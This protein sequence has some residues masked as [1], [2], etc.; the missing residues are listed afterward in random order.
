MHVRDPSVGRKWNTMQETWTVL[1]KKADFYGIASRFGIDPVIARILH[2]RGISTDEEIRSYLFGDL[3]D[4][5]DPFLLLGMREAAELLRRGIA[6]KKRIRVIGDYDIDGVMSAYILRRGLSELGAEAD[7][8]IP[9]R[10]R[11]G[12]GLNDRL[13]R[14]A[15]E[16]GVSIIVTCDNGISAGAQ[17]ALARSLGMQVVVTDHHEVFSMPEAD[18]VVDPKQEGDSYPCKQ[19]C[20]AAVA[21]KLILAMGGDP[22]CDLLQYAAF[23]TVGDVVDL[24]GENRILVKEGLA[25]LRKTD[26][27]GIL[28][29][30]SCCGIR[31]EQIDTY[32]IGYVLGPCFNASGRL[33][34]AFRA[35]R[36][37]ECTS[38]EEAREIARELAELNA[39]RRQMTDNGVREA[40][41]LIDRENM[42]DDPVY[43][44]YLPDVHESI[45]GII[46]G[47]IRE[48]RNHPVFVL[49][50][51]EQGLKGSGRSIPSYS[52]FEKLAEHAG[53]LTKF[54]GHPMAAGLTIPEENLPALREALNRSSGLTEEDFIYRVRIDVPMPVSY[55]N[56]KLIGE[57]EL[58]APFGKENEKPVFAEKNVLFTGAKLIGSSKNVLRAEAASLLPDGSCSRGVTAVCFRNGEALYERI[59]RDPHVSIVYYPSINEYNGRRS[60]QIVVTRFR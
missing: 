39:S 13:I 34:S 12:Y 28:A 60:I 55:V 25:R 6:E 36:L 32:H 15:A 43:V 49:T 23:A 45:A 2:N 29:L 5:H 16:D 9:D 21:W 24:T 54:G 7:F 22:G 38:A 57:L 17:T 52:M 56:E 51:G 8:R 31:P 33:D 40:E 20:G 19:L 3:A 30:C 50:K 47:R 11:D 26:N 59:R 1:M 42:A 53:L 27:P 44:I 46:A 10:I 48:S 4:L 35:E 41:E 14:E 37:L 58:L 18:A